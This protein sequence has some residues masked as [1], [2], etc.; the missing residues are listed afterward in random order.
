M[1]K[2][3]NASRSSRNA[4]SKPWPIWAAALLTVLFLAVPMAAQPCPGGDDQVAYTGVISLEADS[5]RISTYD[6][7]DGRRQ[8]DIWFGQEPIVG[9]VAKDSPA[10]GKLRAGDI[11]VAVNGRFITTREAGTALVHPQSDETLT[12]RLRRRGREMEVALT[13]RMVCPDQVEVPIARL[14]APPPPAPPAPPAPPSSPTPPSP[15]EMPSQAPPA[16]PRPSV[17]EL[18]PVPPAPPAPPAVPSP[19]RPPV[20]ARMGFGFECEDCSLSTNNGVSR[21]RFGQHPRIYSVEPGGPAAQAG[22]RRGDVVLAVDGHDLTSQEGAERFAQVQPGQTVTLRYRRGDQTSS[23]ELTAQEP[24]SRYVGPAEI[25]RAERLRFAGTIGNVDVEVRGIRPV[26][27]TSAE[28]EGVLIIRTQDSTIRITL[29]E[30]P[31]RQ[32]EQQ[33]QK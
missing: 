1:L 4:L 26:T 18:P 15:P 31:A 16:P 13:P 3:L 2:Q 21:F 11:I 29:Q 32:Q 33:Q 24:P 5:I 6:G 27:V 12:L 10:W 17:V 9:S 14:A 25:D 8:R 22:L 19:P 20:L 28:D 23:V 30:R 7:P